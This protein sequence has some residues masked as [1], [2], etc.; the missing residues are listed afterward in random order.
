[1]NIHAIEINEG[2]EVLLVVRRHWFHIAVVAVVDILFFTFF[3]VVVLVT[4]GMFVTEGRALPQH[5]LALAVYALAFCGLIL[6]SHFFAAWSDHWLDVW[7]VTNRRV[8]DIEQKGFFVRHV[9]SFPLDRI[10]DVT[11]ET[12]GIFGTWLHFG[13]VR[14]QTASISEELVMK[15]IPFPEEVKERVSS[16]LHT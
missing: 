11:S 10:Q 13:T 15:E 9:S 16:L 2:E 5:S 4:V 14:M 1:M 6:W 12:R 8:I 7:V 3:A